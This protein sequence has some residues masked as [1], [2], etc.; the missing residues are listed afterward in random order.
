MRVMINKYMKQSDPS[1]Y[2]MLNN[3]Q[4]GGQKTYQI[5]IISTM[6]I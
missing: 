4:I 6:Y 1:L 5:L 3:Y 2:A